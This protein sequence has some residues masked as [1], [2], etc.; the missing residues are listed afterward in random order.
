[1]QR[2]RKIKSAEEIY[3]Y[4]YVFNYGLS[5]QGGGYFADRGVRTG[6]KGGRKSARRGAKLPRWAQGGFAGLISGRVRMRVEAPVAARECR[7]GRE[8]EREG[9]AL[10]LF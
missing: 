9:V 4:L 7:G 6:A 5:G 3:T 2:R 8:G 1:M 10:P